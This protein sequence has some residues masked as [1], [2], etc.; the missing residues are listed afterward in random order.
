ML[1]AAL[2]EILALTM[3][4][5]QRNDWEAASS[6]EPLEQVIDHIKSILRNRHISTL[7]RGAC[8]VEA[9]FIWA[10]LLNDMERTSDHCSNI[11]VSIIDA[12]EHNMNAHESLRSMKKGNPA[13][14]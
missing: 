2:T 3:D 10:D 12:H 7:K 5:L 13:F 8:S 11:A 14:F 6:I 4:A 9:G 1:C